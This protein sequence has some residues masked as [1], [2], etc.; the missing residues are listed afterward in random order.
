M[1]LSDGQVLFQGSVKN[2]YREA[3]MLKRASLKPPQIIQLALLLKIPQTI[4]SVDDM[5]SYL[6]KRAG[7]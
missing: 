7:A 1:V 5:Y 3:E 6:A 4:L 2:V